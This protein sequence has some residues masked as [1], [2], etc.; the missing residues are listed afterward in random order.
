MST[1]YVWRRDGGEEYVDKIPDALSGGHV[2]VGI[3]DLIGYIPQGSVGGGL[4]SMDSPQCWHSYTFDKTTGKYSGSGAS[5][6]LNPSSTT[7]MEPGVA[8]QNRADSGD[9]YPYII[10][11]DGKYVYFWTSKIGQSHVTS[12]DL[13]YWTYYV[14]GKNPLNTGDLA[15]AT[16]CVCVSMIDDDDTK[17]DHYALEFYKI[18]AQVTSGGTST[19]SS[20]NSGAYSGSEYTY[21]GSDSIDPISIYYPTSGVKAGDS[22]TVTVTPSSNTYGGTI[23][24]LYQYNTGSGWVTIQNTHAT[25]IQFDIPS[26]AKSIQFR[27]R[28]QDDWGF[29]SNDYV[30]GPTIYF[31]GEAAG[32][33]W[34]GVGNTARQANGVWVGVNGVAKKVTAMW[35]GVN[36]IAKKVF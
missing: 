10:S 26:T 19:V 22:I 12:Q 25:S 27:A 21:L 5:K 24:Y 15:Y 20:N 13:V 18:T 14:H 1:R 33:V 30:T 11:P 16:N 8:I 7:G 31:A 3:I 9:S 4:G 23:S 29:I 17:Y 34:V 28:A 2:G 32:K 35:V 6:W 36:G